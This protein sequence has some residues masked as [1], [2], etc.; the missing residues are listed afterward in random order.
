VTDP[1]A[2]YREWFAEA[3][4]ARGGSDPKAASLSTVGP[5]GRPSSRIVLI[6]YCDERGFV[7]FTNLESRKS[8]E[9]RARPHVALCVHWAA[10]DKQVRIEGTASQVSD[11]EADRY[12]ATRPRGSQ[13]GAW[14]S[15][16]SRPLASRAVLS[17]RVHDMDSR[18][19]GLPVPRP[20]FWSGFLVT[21]SRVE[22]WVGG[23]GRL[24]HRE[25]MEREGDGWRTSLLF[26]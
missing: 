23:A 7:F 25:L 9:L 14:A 22:F 15:Q 24:H 26:P 4:S 13:I 10:L 8:E 18:F 20:P 6:Q 5:D 21:P 12:F 19:A 1:I 11:E 2:R 16:Q 17:A 3:S